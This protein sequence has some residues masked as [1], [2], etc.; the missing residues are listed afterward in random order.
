MGDMCEFTF[1]SADGIHQVHAVTWSAGEEAKGVVQLTHGLS[2]YILRYDGFARFLNARGFHVV[3]HDHLGHGKT[4]IAP[5][6][7]GCFPEKNGW[8]IVNEDIHTL[9]EWAGK[10]WPGLPHFLLGHSMGSF[11]ARTYLI[12]YPGTIDGC[13]LLGTGQEKAGTVA[14]GKAVA[15]AIIRLKGRNYV[16]KL[17]TQMSL[18]AYNS[19]F[20]PN[21]TGA[22]WISRD[23]AVVDAYIADPLC[24]FKPTVGMFRD[25]MEGLQQIG[26]YDELLKMDRSTPVAFFSGEEDPVGANGQAVKRVYELFREAGCTDVSITLYPG[27]RHEIL[28]EINRQEVYEDILTWIEKHLAE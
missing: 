6:E 8:R 12:N 27:A 1:L 4:A 7:Y 14:A 3:G 2:E 18:G 11:Q 5:W 13:I 10:E 21:R 20:K 19:A 26:R 24:R 23:E 15:G 16:S 17:V 25:M 28:N 22:D 9:R